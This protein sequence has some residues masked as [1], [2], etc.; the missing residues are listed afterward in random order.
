MKKYLTSLL[1][2]LIL[3]FFLVSARAASVETSAYLDWSNF[4]WMGISLTGGSNPI[5]SWISQGEMIELEAQE[6]YYSE[7]AYNWNDNLSYTITT[8]QI[9]VGAN[10]LSDNISSYA[11][12]SSGDGY[13]DTYRWA[14]FQVS[15]SGLIVFTVPYRIE[16][17]IDVG[18]ESEFDYASIDG[19]VYMGV[20]LDGNVSQD[21]YSWATLEKYYNINDCQSDTGEWED[22]GWLSVAFYF[23]DGESGY[24]HAGTYTEVTSAP[25]PSSI[26]LITSGIGLIFI[27]RRGISWE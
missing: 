27:R 7:S 9:E 5:L 16:G 14:Q 4:S 26:L 3:G 8:L 18:P 22:E 10:A 11:T 24:F 6:N 23:N 21:S 15:G 12:A 20:Y 13:G 17:K 2:F 1:T 25:I 19:E